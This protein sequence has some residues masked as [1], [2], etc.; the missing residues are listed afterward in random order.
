MFVECFCCIKEVGVLK[1]M[2][3]L[4]LF[5]L[6][7]EEYQIECFCCLVKEVNLD[8]DFV[9]K[10]LNFIIK[11]VIWYYEVIVVEYNGK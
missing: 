6:V 11:E 4:L 3:E 8:L 7:C 2:Y 10:F 9:E 1:V 5:D